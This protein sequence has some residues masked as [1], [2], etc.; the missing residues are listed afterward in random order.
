MKVEKLKTFKDFERELFDFGDWET[1][2]TNDEGDADSAMVYLGEVQKK[3]DKLKAEAIKWVKE[4]KENLGDLWDLDE[5][6]KHFFNLTEE[7]FIKDYEKIR[8][9]WEKEI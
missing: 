6:I 2:E 5:W 7:D 1:I 9:A 3:F 4:D 8:K